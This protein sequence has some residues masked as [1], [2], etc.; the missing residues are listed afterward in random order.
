MERWNL[1]KMEYWDGKE[2]GLDN[3]FSPDLPISVS[4][5][6]EGDLT[7]MIVETNLELIKDAFSAKN[8]ESDSK[9]LREPD[10]SSNL[11]FVNLDGEIVKIYGDK[12]SIAN[13]DHLWP[14]SSPVYFDAL[15][16]IYTQN[17]VGGSRIDEDPDSV[18]KNRN[19]D[20][21][22]EITFVKGIREL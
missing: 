3:G 16:V 21:W 2:E 15:D 18:F 14:S 8:I 11:P 17:C 10:R 19:G 20:Y 7:D 13:H 1:G 6:L 12:A 9:T 4:D 5:F 22:Q